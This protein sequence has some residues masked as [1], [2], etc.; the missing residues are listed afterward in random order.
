MSSELGVLSAATRQKLAARCVGL[1][2]YLLYRRRRSTL[3]T[4]LLSNS[5]PIKF[6]RWAGHCSRALSV[7]ALLWR[8]TITHHIDPTPLLQTLATTLEPLRYSA[9]RVD[10]IWSSVRQRSKC[11]A[12]RGTFFE[13]TAGVTAHQSRRSSAHGCPAYILLR[14]GLKRKRK[15]AT[16]MSS[17]L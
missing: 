9:G 17:N 3:A 11:R 6:P 8:L 1:R 14:A 5:P 7:H 15:E 4:P 16:R 13:R 12:G 10:S 2:T